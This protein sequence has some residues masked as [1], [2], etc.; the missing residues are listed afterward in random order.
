MRL[1]TQCRAVK[2]SF[3]T[4]LHGPLDSFRQP[5]R[6]SGCQADRLVDVETKNSLN[7]AKSMFS[8]ANISGSFLE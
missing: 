8:V 2:P 6:Q 1:K 5:G 4:V 3:S 7:A